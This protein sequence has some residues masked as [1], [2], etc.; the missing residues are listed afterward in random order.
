MTT[1]D[2][3]KAINDAED[4]HAAMVIANAVAMESMQLE[5]PYADELA[6]RAAWF[7]RWGQ[8]KQQLGYAGPRPGTNWTG[9]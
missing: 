9:D 2:A 5:R 3:I 7:K 1:E 6:V 8:T 4:R